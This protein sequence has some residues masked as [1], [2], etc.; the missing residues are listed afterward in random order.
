MGSRGTE[1]Q[2]LGCK[3][4]FGGFIPIPSTE[5]ER[6]G[7]GCCHTGKAGVELVAG[8]GMQESGDNG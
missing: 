4:G 2:L 1:Y 3:D 7:G 6:G 8:L 5:T